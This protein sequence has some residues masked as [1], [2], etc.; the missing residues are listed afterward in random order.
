MDIKTRRDA[1]RGRKS[2]AGVGKKSKATQEYTPLIFLELYF[3]CF[4]QIFAVLFLFF[5]VLLF[6]LFFILSSLFFFSLFFFSL[7]FFSLFFFLC[8]WRHMH[9]TKAMSVGNSVHSSI[10]QSDL[11]ASMSNFSLATNFSF[12]PLSFV[13]FSFSFSFFVIQN[14]CC[15]VNTEWHSCPYLFSICFLNIFLFTFVFL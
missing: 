13:S 2:K 11:S 4:I 14:L 5:L 12:Y 7:F 3:P 9:M 6:I 15:P 10:C 1:S 8:L